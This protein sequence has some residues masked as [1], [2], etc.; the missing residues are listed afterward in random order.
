[1]RSKKSHTGLWIP[2]HILENKEL[3]S[4][5]KI[6]LSDILVLTKADSCFKSNAGF[7]KIVNIKVR[8]VQRIIKS[9][10]DK[11]Y[12][13]EPKLV[14]GSNFNVD[15]RIL[16]PKS[17]AS[18]IENIEDNKLEENSQISHEPYVKNVVTPMLKKPYIDNNINNNIDN[19]ISIRTD[20][21]IIDLIKNG[22]NLKLTHEESERM[23]EISKLN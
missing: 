3:N 6:I 23:V 21:E 15:K 12:L 4:N 17:K 13:N 20:E 22:D 5:E 11:G 18:K 16:I 1:M 7:A 19:I 8:G 2:I 9:L 10:K 14:Y